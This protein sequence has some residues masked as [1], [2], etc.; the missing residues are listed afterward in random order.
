ME[1]LL[2]TLV[3]IFVGMFVTFA[4]IWCY[5]QGIKIGRSVKENKPLEK[6]IEPKLE[7]ITE[8]DKKQIEELQNQFENL[9]NFQ[10]NF[11]EVSDERN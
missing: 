10:P 1:I 6:V 3:G 7:K 11:T 8:E 4:C 2:G 5:R 9:M